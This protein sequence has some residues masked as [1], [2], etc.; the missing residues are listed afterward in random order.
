MCGICGFWS[1]SSNSRYDFSSLTKEMTRKLSHRG[2]DDEGIWF[3]ENVKIGLG[4][5]RLSIVDLSDAGRQLMISPSGRYVLIFN[6]EIYN[7]KTIRAELSNLG[8]SYN[9]NGYSDTETLLVALEK[10]SLQTV[11]SKC[12]GMFAFALWDTKKGV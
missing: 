5:R 6:G 2:P 8:Y 7:H 9:W 10:F 11:L 1:S 4:H 3:N 12:V